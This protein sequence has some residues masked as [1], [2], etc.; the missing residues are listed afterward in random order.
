MFGILGVIGLLVI[1]SCAVPPPVEP[2]PTII[3]SPIPSDTPGSA[4]GGKYQ[5]PGDY[6]QHFKV[7]GLERWFLVHI[8]IGYQAGK[9]LPLVVN[10]HPLKSTAFAQEQISQMTAKSD[11][12]EFV[13]VY[14]QANGSPPVWHGPIP[15]EVGNADKDYFGVMLQHLRQEISIDSE[16]IYATGFSNGATMTNTLGCEFSETFA[17]IAPVAGGHV[18]FDQCEIDAP[19]SV[20]AIHGTDDAIVAYE[21]DRADV[22]GARVWVEAWAER[23]GCNM[24]PLIES[25]D[26]YS[27]VETWGDCWGNTEVSLLTLKGGG[28]SWPRISSEPI[29]NVFPY[30]DATDVIWEFFSAHPKS[31]KPGDAD[32]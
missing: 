29:P 1:P 10:L 28:H 32:A 3:A 12:E 4:K 18:A 24:E 19:V 17:A 26:E 27:L 13:L 20:L 15:G 23:D 8:P 14:P 31:G 30:L 11:Q 25:D 5:S 16:R 22:P 7:N 2:T 6:I 21:S 9:P